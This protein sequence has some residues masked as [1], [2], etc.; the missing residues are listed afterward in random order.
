MPSLFKKPAPPVVDLDEDS[1][2]PNAKGRPTPTRKE[3]P[4]A[5]RSTPTRRGSSRPS[6]AKPGDPKAAKAAMRETRRL[7]A[8][9]YRAAMNSGDIKR[10]PARERVPERI[11]ARNIVDQ[12]RN[13]GPLLLGLLVIAY[14]LGLAP[15]D[16]LK[17]AAF[18]L[19]GLC[20]IGIIADCI[21]IGRMVTREVHERYPNS[22]VRLKGYVAQRALMPARWRQPRPSPDIVVGRWIPRG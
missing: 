3:A 15:G 16:A 20:L 8:A 4:A 11:M 6:T 5:R 7:K 14:L 9:E 10:L 19:L 17:K 18:Y 22:T 2:R 21:Y 13:F 1:I 12:R